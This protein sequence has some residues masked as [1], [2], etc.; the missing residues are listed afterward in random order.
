M[1]K[2]RDQKAIV[3]ACKR[4]IETHLHEEITNDSLAKQMGIPSRSLWRYFINIGG[5]SATDYIRLRKVHKAARYL[6]HGSS[7]EGALRKLVASGE[8]KREG[9]GKST[10]YYRTK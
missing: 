7:V 6:R 1:R 8:L 2:K 5:Y 10:S 4:Y 3:K 9:S